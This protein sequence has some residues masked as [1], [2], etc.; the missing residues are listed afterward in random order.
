MA[1]A[2]SGHGALARIP[3]LD[4]IRGVA[5]A[6]VMAYHFALVPGGFVGV[7]LFFAMSGFVIVRK[8]LHDVPQAPTRVAA[9]S[10]FWIARCWRLLPALMAMLTV[11]LVVAPFMGERFGDDRRTAA[12]AVTALGGTANWF[13]LA[14][15]DAVLGEARPLLHTWSLSVEEQCYLVLGIALALGRRR[16]RTVAATLAVA[17]VLAG[18]VASL[19]WPGGPGAPTPYFSTLSRLPPLALGVGLAA[20]WHGRPRGRAG[21]GPL[22]IPNDLLTVAL[23]AAL[24]PVVLAGHWDAPLMFPLGIVVIGVVSAG[25]VAATANLP[26]GIVSRA[27]CGRVMQYLGTRS[28]SLYLWHFPVAHLFLGQPAPVRLVLWTATSLAVSE[29]S[30]RLVER[31]MRADGPA[32]ARL[33]VAMPATVLAVPLVAVLW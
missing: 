18:I 1:S 23:L 27:L 4:G 20:W 28:Y 31:P 12:H 32:R 2:Q 10:R 21:V 17:G 13:R 3:A 15:P 8:L 7:D 30:Y 29:L 9:F 24:I 25:I 16:A 14:A 5:I 11:V 22:G 6:L 26:P 33:G 19:V